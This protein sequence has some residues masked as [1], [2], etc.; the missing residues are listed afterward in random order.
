MEDA[1]DQKTAT[2]IRLQK[3]AMEVNAGSEQKNPQLLEALGTWAAFNNNSD[4]SELAPQEVG[5]GLGL[6]KVSSAKDADMNGN[7]R[8]VVD[9]NAHVGTKV[10]QNESLR[11]VS[12]SDATKKLHR[13]DLERIEELE[14]QV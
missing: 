4:T 11:R 1:L 13:K 8:K 6:A 7:K 9:M 2:L 14:K 10:T 3:V 12:A 5:V